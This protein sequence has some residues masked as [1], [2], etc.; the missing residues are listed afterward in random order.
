[1]RLRSGKNGSITMVQTRQKLYLET[2]A[3]TFAVMLMC[4][5]CGPSLLAEDACCSVV[6]HAL[7]AVDRIKPGMNRKEV[8]KFFIEDGGVFFRDDGTYVF[9]SC[10]YIKV[11]IKFSRAANS[12]SNNFSE[13]TVT[14]VS[15]PYLQAP[16]RD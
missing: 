6:Q 7:S 12:T 11:K 13:D 4:H 14:E 8:E 9:R 16:M 5:V 10:Q 2:L 15:A 3:I 1:M